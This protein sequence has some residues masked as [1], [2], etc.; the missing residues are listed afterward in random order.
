M[1]QSSYGTVGLPAWLALAGILVVAAAS[2]AHAQDR[3]RVIR[4]ENFRQEPG[5]G[6]RLLGRVN[7]GTELAGGARSGRWIE[8]TLEGWIWVQSVRP[9]TQA[10]F[11]L[12]VSRS[13][14]ENLRDEPN[15]N[16]L[17]R[18]LTGFL[19]EEMERRTGWVR[20]RRTG[21]MWSQSLTGVSEPATQATGDAAATQPPPNE[22]RLDR[23]RTAGRMSLLAGP[24]GDT[25]GV[26]RTGTAVRVVTRSGE[27]ARVSVEGWVR[28]VDLESGADGVLTGVTRT[29]VRSRP[30]EFQGQLLRWT[31]QY[32]SLQN[33]DE[34]RRG[35]PADRRYM[36]ARGPV[37]ERGFVYVVL[38]EEQIA[39]IE[40]LPPLAEMTIIGR[41][42]AAR[43]QYLG[44]PIL[45]LVDFAVVQP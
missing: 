21:W 24:D 25:L 5:S 35:I 7:E 8:V 31:V 20:V 13:G 17:A 42:R 26:L 43:S 44:N 32:I 6:G 4:A 29:E 3:F 37:P 18:L 19:L 23:A 16:I 22:A 41:V 28:A 1:K 15:G 9:E 45:E 34:L 27:W 40:D 38:T 30:A 39:A 36:L 11:D 33:A 10:G 12:A 14:G 2:E